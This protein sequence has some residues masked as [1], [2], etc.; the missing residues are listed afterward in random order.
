MMRKFI[1]TVAIF[2]V[3]GIMQGCGTEIT[4]CGVSV[5]E[6]RAPVAYSPGEVVIENGFG[7]E[8]SLGYSSKAK[9]FAGGEGICVKY[10]GNNKI[11][12]IYK[13]DDSNGE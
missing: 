5:V 9:P 11:L 10:S 1:K 12:S 4:D 7:E 2:I 3:A 13:E 6:V 8:Y